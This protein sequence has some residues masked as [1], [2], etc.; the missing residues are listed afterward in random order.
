MCISPMS[1]HDTTKERVMTMVAPR[2]LK[3][4]V[5]PLAVLCALF[6]G[7]A[8][9]LVTR[10]PSRVPTAPAPAAAPALLPAVA[11]PAFSIA[12]ES[13]EFGPNANAEPG[14]GWA[15]IRGSTNLPNGTLLTVS[16]YRKNMF[17]DAS[18]GDSWVAVKE[19]GEQQAVV[20]DGRFATGLVLIS[21]PKP[22]AP[23]S[24]SEN[25]V[26]DRTLAK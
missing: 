20:Q 8:V 3:Q 2:F 19:M 23:R 7:V 22:S 11:N 18:T 6:L 17:T 26:F 21:E 12:I 16:I 10:T 14:K 24:V 4:I 15:K 1:R 5:G 9:A 13:G 25:S